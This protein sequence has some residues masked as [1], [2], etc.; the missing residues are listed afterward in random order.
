MRLRQGL[1][2][3]KN[4]VSIRILQSIGLEYAQDY[5]TKFGF[6]RDKVGP[7][8]TMALGAV[9]V[10]PWQMLGGYAVF[11]NGGYRINPY[12][13]QRIEDG[14]GN[15][16]SETV[17]VVAG[18][19]AEQ[20]LDIRNT[21]TMVNMLQDV[22][23]HGTAIRAMA[24]GR[25]DLAGKTGTTSESMDAWFC[26]FHPTLVAITWVGYDNPRSLGEKETGGGAALPIWM[27]YM[28]KILKDEPQIEYLVPPGIVTARIN[29]EGLRDPAGE[30]IE[31]FYEE[32]LPPERNSFLPDL[33][34]PTEKDSDQL[35]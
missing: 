32:F 29:E 33:F 13:I 23:K 19:D 20:I 1:T 22:V 5:V 27:D 24:L 7:Y 35:F 31:Y 12:L 34:K 18:K 17:P 15:L 4:L 11:A 6:D 30:R 28:G 10:T 16:I 2:K 3:S 14:Q 21:F 25:Q 26:G 9:S 8:L